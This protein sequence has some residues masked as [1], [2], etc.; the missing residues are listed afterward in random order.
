MHSAMH[1]TEKISKH[2]KQ[3]LPLYIFINIMN[4]TKIKKNELRCVNIIVYRRH[5][6]KRPKHIQ[7]NK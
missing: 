6:I 2:P 4:G 1:S 3:A 7:V 5:K